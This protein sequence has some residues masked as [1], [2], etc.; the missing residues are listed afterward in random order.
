MAQHL[1]SNDISN[2]TAVWPLNPVSKH[3]SFQTF[4]KTPTTLAF[5]PYLKAA[6]MS[7]KNGP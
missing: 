2:V 4:T 3:E 7:S 5:P 1:L 6:L